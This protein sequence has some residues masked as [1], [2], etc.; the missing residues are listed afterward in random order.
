MQ[1]SGPFTRKTLPAN[2]ARNFDGTVSRCFASS[3]CS[4]LPLKAKAHVSGGPVKSSRS[5]VAEWEEPRHPGPAVPAG[6]YPTPSHSA[7]Q[8][9]SPIPPRRLRFRLRT[10]LPCKWAASQVGGE[11]V[12]G[13]PRRQDAVQIACL[14]AGLQF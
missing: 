11:V 7:T 6:Q 3:V 10:H 13:A 2:C 9:A 8:L 5:E 14:H 12:A 1:R 4:K